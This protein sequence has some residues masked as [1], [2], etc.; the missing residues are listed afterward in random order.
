MT[1]EV[2]QRDTRI[3]NSFLN[4]PKSINILELHN[5]FKYDK[6]TEVYVLKAY[7]M[8]QKHSQKHKDF[9]EAIL[10]AW[11]TEN[12]YITHWFAVVSLAALLLA[13]DQKK[14]SPL[15]SFLN[16]EEKESV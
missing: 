2:S 1:V 9:C 14:Y 7:L 8:L 6:A 16:K 15:E 10:K 11:A 5:K 3:F 4:N 13:T 12:V